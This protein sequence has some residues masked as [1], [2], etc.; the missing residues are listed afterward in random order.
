MRLSTLASSFK[1]RHFL[2]LAGNGI[3]AVFG[4]LSN[5]L[6]FRLLSEREM[7]SWLIYQ[8]IFVLID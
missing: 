7:G 2:S 6:L 5:A 4:L 8:S 1:N 3:M